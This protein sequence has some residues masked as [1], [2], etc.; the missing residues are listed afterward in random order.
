MKERADHL[1]QQ[2]RPGKTDGIFPPKALRG[3]E[4]VGFNDIV[5]DPGG[6][7][8]RGLLFID[9]GVTTATAF[10]LRLALLYLQPKGIV[11]QPDTKYPDQL[12]WSTYAATA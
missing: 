10:A 8:R 2:V 1:G 5:V 3:T 6:V 11:L 12:P 7:V 4:S 9:D